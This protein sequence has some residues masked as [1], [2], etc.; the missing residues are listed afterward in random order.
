MRIEV[1]PRLARASGVLPHDIPGKKEI[2]A[3]NKPSMGW[4]F[5]YGRSP[6]IPHLRAHRVAGME[7]AGAQDLRPQA[8][9][10]AQT[11]DHG[12]FG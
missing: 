8:A 11:L 6:A 3:G 7:R 5:D 12:L 2:G 4:F 1:R 9:A 10:V